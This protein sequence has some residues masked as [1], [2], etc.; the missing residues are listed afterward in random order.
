MHETEQPR[1]HRYRGYP[2][3]DDEQERQTYHYEP[4]DWW[5]IP[6]LVVRYGVTSIWHAVTG[7]R[8]TL[9]L[10]GEPPARQGRRVNP[11]DVRSET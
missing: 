10:A 6:I 5:R 8:R 3:D 9:E 11:P 2:L 4:G 7:R 1:A